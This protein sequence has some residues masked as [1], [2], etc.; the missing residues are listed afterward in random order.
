MLAPES[1]HRLRAVRKVT[2]GVFYFNLCV[3][4]TLMKS[5]NILELSSLWSNLILVRQMGG[6][7]KN[8]GS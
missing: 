5:K 1:K 7:A 4:Q 2:T 3:W 6:A 8:E